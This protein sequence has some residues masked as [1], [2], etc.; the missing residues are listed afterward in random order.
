MDKAPAH[1]GALHYY[2]HAVESVDPRRGEVAADRLRG[3]TP[4]FVLVPQSGNPARL[5][6]VSRSERGVYNGARYLRD[7]LVDG[8]SGD[9]PWVSTNPLGSTKRMIVP[10]RPEARTVSG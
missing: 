5:L 2:I 10:R 8:R 9:L 3:L 6:V 1:V 7:F 4:G